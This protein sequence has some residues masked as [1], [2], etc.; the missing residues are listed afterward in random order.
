METKKCTK[1]KEEKEIT[2]F[3]YRDKKNKTLKSHCKN[4]I[5]KRMSKWIN[6]NKDNVAK[7]KRKWKINQ[8]KI[9]PIYKLD[10]NI[11]K[12][13]L[14]AFKKGLNQTSKKA[15][16][17]EILGCTIIE[18]LDHIE[19]KFQDGM[20]FQNHGIKGWHLDHIT[21]T[22]FAETEKELLLLNHYTNFQP[23]WAKDNYKKSNKI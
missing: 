21:P 16:A 17:E 3:G 11:R 8:K 6:E 14:N 12:I 15:K 20:T 13:I 18:F 2:L 19:S 7:N 10:E 23:L 9:N 4:C 22:C 1:C 5:S